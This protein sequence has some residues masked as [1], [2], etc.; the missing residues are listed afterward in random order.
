MEAKLSANSKQ[1][2]R[3]TRRASALKHGAFSVMTILPG[4][5]EAEFDRLHAELIEEWAPKGPTEQDAVLDLAKGFWRKARLQ[6]FLDAKVTECGADPN[7][8]LFTHHYPG[9]L[10]KA[11]VS[12]ESFRPEEVKCFISQLP[13]ED[14]EYLNKECA[15]QGFNSDAEWIAAIKNQITTVLYPRELKY[16]VGI[17]SDGVVLGASAEFFSPDVWLHELTTEERINAQID[18]AT[19]RLIQLKSMKQ[20]LDQ[21]LLK[22]ESNSNARPIGKAG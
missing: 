11:S 5:D 8:K 10:C 7:H 9:I 19:K 2:R 17:A 14:A 3:K 12:I 13:K 15:R 20:T 22:N 21:L 1:P 18:R 16:A 6:R 4:E